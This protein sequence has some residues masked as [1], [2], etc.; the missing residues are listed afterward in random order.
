MPKVK[1]RN[2]CGSVVRVFTGI[3]RRHQVVDSRDKP[4]PKPM[5]G[6]RAVIRSQEEGAFMNMGPQYRSQYIVLL[7]LGIP[8]E[9]SSLCKVE[10]LGGSS[11]TLWSR[12]S[13]NVLKCTR[14]HDPGPSCWRFLAF[15]CGHQTFRAP[16]ALPDPK[17]FSPQA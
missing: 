10:L 9:R 1:T 5:S 14:S 16:N 17:P 3:P 11:S 4:N 2:P 6:R 15:D 13:V 7:I 12:G 8:M